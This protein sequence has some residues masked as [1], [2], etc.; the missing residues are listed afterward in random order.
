MISNTLVKIREQYDSFSKK[1]K[2]IAKYVLDNPLEVSMMTVSEISKATKVSTATVV[3]FCYTLGHDGFKEFS[4]CFYHEV[5]DSIEPKEDG[6]KNI[7]DEKLDINQ[8]VHKISN[9]NVDAIKNSISLLDYDSLEKAINL[10]L[11]ANKV[12]VYAIGGSAIVA[13]D[14]VFK[15][16]RIGIDIQAFD[17]PHSQ[18]F[19]AS[20]LKDGD[21][22]LFISYTGETKDLIKTAKVVMKTP[23]KSIA[24]S[25]FGENSLSKLVDINIHHSSLGQGVRH[26]STQSRIAQLNI[27]DILFSF[28]VKSRRNELKKFYELTDECFIDT[29]TLD[30]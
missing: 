7:P 9:A 5:I 20:I 2:R 22:A 24:I 17:A 19:S 28:L 21:V 13:Q 23:A 8:A 6:C 16:Q 1:E 10:L 15:F 12:Y 29:L 11:S 14:V 26:T 18:I 3:R 27:V 4:R 30:A 25:R